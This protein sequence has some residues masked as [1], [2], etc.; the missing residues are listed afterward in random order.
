MLAEPGVDFE[1]DQLFVAAIE[2]TNRDNSSAAIAYLEKLLA[3]APQHS[4]SRYL[5]G[6]LYAAEGRYEQ[7]K[8]QLARAIELDPS[9]PE[10]AHYQ[11]GLFH[12]IAG[13]WEHA[14]RVWKPFVHLPDDHPLA[15]FAKGLE[16]LAKKNLNASLQTLTKA[17]TRNRGNPTLNL[18]IRK[19]IRTIQSLIVENNRSADRY[20]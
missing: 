2:E 18:E 1:L 3:M 6:T 17:I 12:L 14:R 5:L 16:Q 19:I 4:G 10:S 7:A 13:E 20:V 15:L 9:L 8:D 11:L